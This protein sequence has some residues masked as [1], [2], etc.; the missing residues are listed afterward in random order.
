MIHDLLFGP[1]QEFG[2]LRRALVGCLALALAAPPLGV[3]LMLRRMSLTADVL[4]HGILPGVAAGFLLAGLSLPAMALGGALAGL[5]VAVGAGALSRATGGREDASLAALYLVALA[6][7]VALVSWRGGAV[8][9]TNLLFGSV[10]GVDDAALLLM[11]GAATLTLPVLALAW[12]PLVL[13]CLDPSFARAVGARGAWWH[14]AFLALVVL[15]L[16]AAFQALG[17]L[18][19]VGLMM[20]PAIAARHWATRVGGIVYAAVAIA[21]LSAYAGLLLSFHADVPSGPAV[22]LA[23]GLAWLVSVLLGP[24][25]GLLPRFWRR[26]HLAG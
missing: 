12:R 16:I 25:D 2:F 6:L 10:L 8:E 9:L 4:G 14:M 17:T 24:V 23:A 15:N 3:F 26:P 22:V 1:F 19:S 7:G 21:A 20:L 11:A 18:M 13:E 5:V